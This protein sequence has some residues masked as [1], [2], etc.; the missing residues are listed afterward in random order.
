MVSHPDLYPSC[1][2]NRDFVA[3]VYRDHRR[4]LC[5]SSE[6]VVG[7]E[8]EYVVYPIYR[9]GERFCNAADFF[10]VRQS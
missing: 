1:V 3:G 2:N 8:N 9:N 10:R 4:V 7:K 5:E 6:W